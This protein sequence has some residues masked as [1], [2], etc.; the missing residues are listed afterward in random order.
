M[1]G[2]LVVD[3][4]TITGYN[5]NAVNGIAK[6]WVTYNGVSQTTL[7][8]YNISSITRTS[9]GNYTL[10]FINA[11]TDANYAILFGVCGGTTVNNSSFVGGVI[12]TTQYGAPS[13]KTTTACQIQ[14]VDYTA[15]PH[16]FTQIY[17]AC[18]R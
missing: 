10:N 16:D 5:G 7:A 14:F 17:V 6:A 18:F 13:N 2:T 11:F 3:A 12:A 9:A 8:S 1:A 15:T 4:L